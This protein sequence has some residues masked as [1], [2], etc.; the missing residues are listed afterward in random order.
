MEGRS[1]PV[2]S[3]QKRGSNVPSIGTQKSVETTLK[4]KKTLGT[5]GVPTV[6]S[7]VQ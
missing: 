3:Y 1:I 4:K 5:S 7:N 6:C 2:L